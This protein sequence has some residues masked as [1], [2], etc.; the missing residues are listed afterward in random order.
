MVKTGFVRLSL[1]LAL[2]AGPPV[3]AHGQA[4]AGPVP[5]TSDSA[6][7]KPSARGGRW[8]RT[9]AFRTLAAP[10]VLA[11]YG[12]SAFG[13][14]GFPVSSRDVYR[15]RQT[16]FPRFRTWADDFILLLPAWGANIL[17]ASKRCCSCFRG[18]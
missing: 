12:V 8:H 18:R 7:A 1:A 11:G 14:R 6:R 5:A 13:E 17:P 3:T 15:A 9:A 2:L 4:P 16:Y 10:A